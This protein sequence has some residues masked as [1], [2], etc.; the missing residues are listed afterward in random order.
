MTTPN[1]HAVYSTRPPN[2]NAKPRHLAVCPTALNRFYVPVSTI[3]RV[4][5][6]LAFPAKITVLFDSPFVGN[7]HF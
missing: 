1:M 7:Q 5:V 4:S 2:S 3:A 6:S